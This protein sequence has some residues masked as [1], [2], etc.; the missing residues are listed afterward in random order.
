ER[1]ERGGKKER[2]ERGGGET[3]VVRGEVIVKDK[4]GKYVKDL[5]AEDFSVFENG[6]AQKV[7]FFEPPLGAGGA[8]PP[9]SAVPAAPATQGATSH[10]PRANLISL[11]LDGATTD[12]GNFKQVREGTLKY[13]QERITDTDTVA[14]FGIANDLQLLQSFT[15]DKS[16]LI[17]PVGKAAT[18]PPGNKN[19]ERGQ[20]T[21]AIAGK[22]AELSSLGEINPSQA[23]SGSSAGA[24][25]AAQGSAAQQAA[26]ANR[27]LQQF[28]LLRSQLSVQQARPVLAALAAI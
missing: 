13:I 7:E 19:T 8:S 26:I 10:E 5:K 6:V 11:V 3:G 17:A 16:K 18:F 12:L 2:E 15:H 28:K 9:K 23:P 14:V 4:K 27:V 24:V 1:E 22:N 25:A 20:V 21:E